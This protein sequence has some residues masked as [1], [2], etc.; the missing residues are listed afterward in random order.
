MSHVEVSPKSYQIRFYD[1]NGDYASSMQM[2]IEGDRGIIHSLAGHGFYKI[3]E[4][5]IHKAFA[6]TGTTVWHANI[7]DWHVEVM[8]EKLGHVLDIH[9][10]GRG[11][12]S[13]YAMNW[14][15]ARLK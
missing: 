15:E 13:G 10:I 1:E 11:E 8:R 14:I 4:Q 7:Q 2:H 9:V 5:H 12:I 3:I 6:L